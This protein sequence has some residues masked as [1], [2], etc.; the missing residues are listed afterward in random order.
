MI[1]EI[2][3]I[4]VVIG[5]VLALVILRPEWAVMG[6]GVLLFVQSALIRLDPLPAEVR[7]GISRGDEVVLLAL[8]LRTAVV[9]AIRRR[10]EL[11]PAV[12]PLIIFGVIGV[13]SGLANDVQPV[14]AALGVYLSVKA[15]L[16]LFVAYHLRVDQRT[17]VR[18]C[19]VIGGLFIGAVLVAVVQ[20]AGVV[21]PWE[22]HVRPVGEVA[23]TSI[24][25]QHTVFGSALA[26]AVGLAVAAFRLPGE[27]LGAA[28]LAGTAGLGIILSSVRRLLISLPVAAVATYL[29]L[30]GDER[31]RLREAARALRRPMALAGL[32]VAAVVLAV[33]I[34]PRMVRLATS[35]W[36][37]YVVDLASRDRYVLYEGA[38]ELLGRSPLLGRGPGTYGSY[39]TIIFDS[40]AYNE[41]GVH[42]RDG[43]KMGAP[44]AS[45]AGEYGLY[46]VLAF[47]AF[48]VLLGRALLPLARGTPGTLS[49]ALAVA[50]IFMLVDMSIESVV[51]VSFS[52]SFVSFFVFVGIGSAL[53]LGATGSPSPPEP[54]RPELIGGHWRRNAVIGSLLFMAVTVA[55]VMLVA[56]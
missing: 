27:R 30:P 19:Y 53:R 15:G 20:F 10:F 13:V 54:W 37:Q 29:A 56:R 28:V 24:F 45:L 47:A 32:A 38:V 25:N 22:P 44:Y 40:P 52:N 42:L 49:T 51:H 21:M 6:L 48:V 3:L 23:A 9:L 50:G 5:A 43:L 36:D 14:A 55:T 18:Y 39:V 46:G 12:W 7:Q 33:V 26:V 35:A 16:W 8:V 31:S 41:V 11:P 34:G 2:V 17:L 1:L 4:G